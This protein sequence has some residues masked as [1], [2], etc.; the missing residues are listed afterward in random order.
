MGCSMAVGGIVVGGIV[1][2]W[3][4]CML[5]S[6]FAMLCVR[7]MVKDW[8]P[9]GG[10]QKNLASGTCVLPCLDLLSSLSRFSPFIQQGQ[11]T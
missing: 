9:G 4:S 10:F 1:A 8:V 5:V 7:G 6:I 2:N 11:E 3:D